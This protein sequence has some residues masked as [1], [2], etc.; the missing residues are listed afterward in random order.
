MAENRTF[1]FHGLGYGNSPVNITATVYGTQIFSGNITTIDLP[2]NPYPEPIPEWKE[3]MFSWANVANLSTDF[4]G[5]VA[6]TLTVNSGSGVI[7]DDITCNW[8][9]DWASSNEIVEGTATNFYTC[10]AGTPP[11]SEDTY[12]I[13]SNVFIDGQRQVPPLPPS[14]GIWE[15]LV[16]N[17]QTITCNWNIGI[18]LVGNVGGDTRN[19]TGSYPIAQ[20]WY[21]KPVD[22]N[23]SI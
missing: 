16:L 4:T 23:G 2:V 7:L 18:G 17:G 15:W 22:E 1:K 8:I 9:G 6:M 11:N 5:N 12:D 10:F 21:P 14:T 19:Y 13:R 3:I 20:E